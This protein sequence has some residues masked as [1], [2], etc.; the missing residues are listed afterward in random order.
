MT[1]APVAVQVI[2]FI[3]AMWWGVVSIIIGIR[4][5]DVLGQIR[6]ALRGVWKE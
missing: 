5:V 1:D 2:L 6:D 3:L 4:L